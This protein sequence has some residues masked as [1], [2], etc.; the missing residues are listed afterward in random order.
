MPETAAGLPAALAELPDPR[1]RRGVRRRLTVVVTAAVCGVLAGSRSYA[2]IA[3]WLE[4]IR[5][6]MLRR[7]DPP[8]A[9][10][11]SAISASES[12]K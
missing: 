3:E 4:D 8:A 6:E 12:P 9:S 2:A 10:A 11:D 1:A 7:P 5:L